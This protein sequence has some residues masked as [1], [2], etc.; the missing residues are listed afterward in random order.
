MTIVVAYKWAADPQEASVTADGTV[1][2]S[3]AKPVVSEY[4][5]AAMAAGRR[6]ADDTGQTIV[7]LTVGGP[8]A[9]TPMAAKAALARGLDEVVV[10]AGPGLAAADTVATAQLLAEAIGGLEDVRLVLAG[11]CSIDVGARM[12][13]AV[14]GGCLGWP[15][16]TDVRSLHVLGER[17][18]VTRQIAEGT[19]T[20]DLPLPAV[21]ALSP[22]AAAPQVPGMKDILAAGKKPVTVIGDREVPDGPHGT[23]LATA[24]VSGPS[25]RGIV[26]DASDVTE[27]AGRLAVL[28]GSGETAGLT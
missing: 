26:I 10:V 22:D 25:R 8:A 1:D 14:L 6:I 7:G 23:V 15:T 16:L 27:A 3:R 4:D 2:F 18:R 28:L 17:A 9:S 11:D 20:L 19:Q 5:A 12:V 24:K 13:P 21:I